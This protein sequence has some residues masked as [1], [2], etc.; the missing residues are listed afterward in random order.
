[1]AEWVY[2]G[3]V[4][5]I[6]LLAAVLFLL[7]AGSAQA[8]FAPANDPIANSPDMRESD[9]A[10]D[11]AGD[12]LLAW[13]VAPEGGGAATVSARWLSP[14]GDPGPVSVLSQA[15][16]VP[17]DP[18]VAA[19]P[20]GRA[21]VAWR[22]LG[23]SPFEGTD[24]RGRWVERDGSLGP[25]VTVCVHDPGK[26]DPVEILD[27]VDPAGVATVTWRNQKGGF[28][29]LELRRV[30]PDSS[31]SEIV[32]K[33][34]VGTIENR[35]SALPDGG[36]LAVYRDVG[37]EANVTGPEGAARTPHKI[38][39]G[40][41]EA[42][43]ELATAGNGS[44]IVTWR[45]S[46]KEGTW[47]VKGIGLDTAGQP[48]SEE[49]TLVPE[50][51]EGAAPDGIAADSVGNFLATYTFFPGNGTT[52]SFVVGVDSGGRPT[53]QGQAFT[54]GKGSTNDI[55]PALYD[56]GVGAVAWRQFEKPTSRILGRTL[57]RS[58]VPSGGQVELGEGVGVDVATIPAL[59]FSAFLVKTRSGVEVR[60]F[61]E[62]PRCSRGEA[63]VQQGR[64]TKVTLSCK[65]LAIENGLIAAPPSH[66]GLAPI[67]VASRSVLYT[68]KPGFEGSD[69]FSYALANDGG[70][71]D[72]ATVTI[73]VGKDT[74][75]PRI[76]RLR[77]VRKKGKLK[78]VV[79][80]SEPGRV[81]I[82]IGSSR[83]KGRKPKKVGKLKSKKAGVKLTLPV[84][85]RLAKKLG[86]GGR[87]RATAVA[88]DLAGNKSRPKRLKFKVQ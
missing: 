87:F 8:G 9:L 64:P 62:P 55:S 19:G 16:E 69:S 13:E 79:K 50:T 53:G 32:P 54:D 74:V 84:K 26:I 12:T 75:K 24:V 56:D 1:M 39:N 22:D 52:T 73:K 66:G 59:G 78:F 14:A 60:R 2:D 46:P 29:A 6:A 27:V 41:L 48:A 40:R 20:A 81:K 63:V 18:K 61:L 67:D 72:P 51:E 34:G 47:A 7:L 43:P 44:S 45:E 25:I 10:T 4:H 57:D 28:S 36:T 37:I 58:G 3:P 82:A 65:G 11:A 86:A 5:R 77:L 35:I 68:P 83:G 80:L 38:S 21:F 42:F 15:P 71:A 76:K 49:L 70:A 33:A 31:L 88:T 17:F 85:G 23:S 30:M